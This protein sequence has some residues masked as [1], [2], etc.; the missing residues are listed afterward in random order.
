[1]YAGTKMQVPENSF[2]SAR[3]G[4]TRGRRLGTCV[5][6]MVVA[7]GIVA[8]RPTTAGGE[9]KSGPWVQLSL[10][11]LGFPGVSGPFLNSGSSMLT[12]HFL[13]GSHLLVTYGL[14]GLVPRLPGDPVDHDDRLVAGEVVDLP[15]GNISARTEWHMH[16][17]GRY[18]WKLGDGR[19][20][21]RIGEQLYTIAPLANLASGDAFMRT[22]FPG[23]GMRPSA[24]FVSPEGGVVTLETVLESP[25]G[26]TSRVAALG[27]QDT[28]IAASK[29]IIDFFRV[30][31]EKKD[32]ADLTVRAAGNV[33]SSVPLLLPVDA[34]GYLWADEVDSNLWAV[35]FNGY[36][37]KTVELG[38]VQSSC[39]PR[40]QMI[41]RS[42]MLELTCL[43]SDDR[44]KI[45]SYGLDGRETWEDPVGDVGVPSFTFAPAAARFAIST[46]RV[47]EYA[48]QPG[49]QTPNTGPTQEVRVYQNA[50]GD[51]LL[52]VDC[53]PA[54]K[55]AENF[56]L[57]P[58]GMLAAVVREGKIAVYKLPPLEKRDVEDMAAVEKF[59]P[60]SSDENVNLKRL[61][62][63][64]KA[65]MA[66][67]TLAASTTTEADANAK[68]LVSPGAPPPGPRKPPTL[69]KPGEKPEFG[70][71]NEQPD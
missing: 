6:W 12:V 3:S 11:S 20:L 35:T 5:V 70:S 39:R 58:D 59:A 63:P 4:Q 54:F 57:S 34:D 52:R 27:D 71:A 25:D 66:A 65:A 41:S 50:S 44:V 16:D 36:G 8:V 31:G 19:F 33:L 32:G 55:T 24:V 48:P 29:T 45:A 60:P 40:L 18:L 23:R 56:D 21:I 69:L 64:V 1:M 22:L 9:K 28:A 37:G 7:L 15:S 17:H 67:E 61:T 14:R 68:A 47:E 10:D 53:T 51:L 42:E 2:R 38:K 62:T 30:Q 49:A 26:R 13:D 46:S 43:G